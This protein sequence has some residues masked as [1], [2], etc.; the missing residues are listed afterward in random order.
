MLVELYCAYSCA[1][2]F[3]ISALHPLKRETLYF[4][5]LFGVYFYTPYPAGLSDASN[6]IYAFSRIVHLCEITFF[7][8]YFSFSM[9]FLA[10]SLIHRRCSSLTAA[11]APSSMP[12]KINI[13]MSLFFSA[14]QKLYIVSLC[15][16]VICD[17]FNGL[18]SQKIKWQK[19]NKSWIEYI[20]PF[21]VGLK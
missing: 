16:S 21:Y 2:F 13:R 9:L 5:T 7:C 18:L 19:K 11:P 20:E 6:D 12:P 1:I 17:N 4:T 3:P 14:N 8:Y 15:V 10:S